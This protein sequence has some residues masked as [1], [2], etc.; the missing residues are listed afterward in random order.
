MREAPDGT[1][2]PEHGRAAWPGE[3]LALRGR[4][5]AALPRVPIDDTEPVARRSALLIAD[6]LQSVERFSESVWRAAGWLA[7]KPWILLPG[8]AG[9]ALALRVFRIGRQ[10]LWYDEAFSLTVARWP[11]DQMKERILAGSADHPP[12]YYYLLH[13]WMALIGFGDVQARL[14]S[15][16]L[17]MLMVLALYVL[18]SYLFDRQTGLIAAL[19]AT[20]SQIAILYSQE[21]RSYSLLMLLAVVIAYLFIRALRLRSR[22]AWIGL[23]LT[24]VVLCLSHYFGV[25]LMIALGCYALTLRAQFRI[26]L[27]WLVIWAGAVIAGYL[28]WLSGDTVERIL[29]DESFRSGVRLE[30]PPWFR[31]GPWSVLEILD[32]FNNANTQGALGPPPIHASLLGLFLL[33]VPILYCCYSTFRENETMYQVLSDMRFYTLMIFLLPV[34]MIL[35][36]GFVQLKYNVRY[37]VFCAPVYYLLASIGLGRIRPSALRLAMVSA[38]L[39]LSILSLRSIYSFP[40]KENYRDALGWLATEYVAPD[41]VVFLPFGEPPLEWAIYHGDGPQLNTVSVAD[42]S[43]APDRCPRLWLVAY[44]KIP[45]A[46][47]RVNEGRQVIARTHHLAQERHFF[48]ISVQRYDQSDS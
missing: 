10:S 14:L 1:G 31:A 12:L 22:L 42:L 37:L 16:V 32:T 13:L 48:W 7:G 33:T 5:A 20:F 28:A 15:A 24:S 18:G 46:E 11:I 45:W 30:Q 36:M 29:S 23:S 26:P 34:M 41:C 44:L 19:L 40:Y 38:A 21:A 3:S 4:G 25:A 17:G 8:L 35:G 6:V 9:L 43:A 47:D 39:I 2:D 27:I